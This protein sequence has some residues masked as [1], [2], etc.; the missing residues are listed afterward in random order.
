VSAPLS[1]VELQDAV[2]QVARDLR[3]VDSAIQRLNVTIAPIALWSIRGIKHQLDSLRPRY[4]AC[5][6]SIARQGASP[7]NPAAGGQAGLVAAEGSAYTAG[8]ITLLELRDRWTRV[9]SSLDRVTAQGLGWLAIWLGAL[10]IL[11]ALLSLL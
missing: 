8:L 3:V 10:S 4:A 6:S 5:V 1:G 11:L 9:D 7:D 2:R